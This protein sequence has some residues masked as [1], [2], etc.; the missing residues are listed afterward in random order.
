[1][2]RYVKAI[3]AFFECGP[4]EA[5]Q[6]LEDREVKALTIEATT[7]TPYVEYEVSYEIDMQDSRTTRIGYPAF[8]L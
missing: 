4:L 5:L 7:K 2:K 1:M 3:A 6:L 8:Q